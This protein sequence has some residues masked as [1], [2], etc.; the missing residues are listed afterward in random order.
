MIGRAEML[1][2]AAQL[3]L[4]PDIVEKDY[5]LG[6]MLA[7]IGQHPEASQTW[8]FKGGTCLKKVHFETYR[9]SEDLDFTL[10]DGHQ[11]EQGVLLR[12]LREIATRVYDLSGVR[13]PPDQIR[14]EVFLN[15]RGRQSAEARLY[16]LGPIARTGST[17]AIRF[18]LTADEI[19]VLPPERRRIVHPYSDDPEDGITVL[20]YPFAEVFAE[21]IRALGERCRPRDLYDVV[22]LFR[23]PEAHPQVRAVRKIL[24][25]K[26]NHKSIAV[27]GL[28]TVTPHR[29]E[30]E[31]E[32]KNMLAAQLP[33]LPDVDAYWSVLPKIFEWLRTEIAPAMPPPKSLA[34][35]ESV[36]R[37]GLRELPRLGGRTS[38]LEAIRFAGANHLCVDLEYV[39][40]QGERSTRTIE[41]YSLRRTREGH[42]L[43]HAERADGRGHRAYRVDRILG[44]TVTNQ[45][46]APRFAVE[47]T[48]EGSQPIR[49]AASVSAA[50]PSAKWHAHAST[51][52]TYV[53]ECNLCGRRF[54]RRT[55]DTN[56]KPHK[57]KNDWQCPGRTGWLVDT[58]Y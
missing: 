29:A 6:W 22:H 41:P 38:A 19:M 7:A 40:D 54:H 51:G 5:V 23:R 16:Y 25:A 31:A 35:G 3:S 39:T 30:V 14:V 50:Y 42:V 1:E 56:L 44:A 21:K 49:D 26:C 55:R 34:A 24:E 47:L 46:F 53:Y 15:P 13:I 10:L 37:L 52:P 8:V 45:S 32:W 27:P 18:D 36:I 11:V 2:F 48:P 33:Q 58:R 4:R 9:F 28:A 57:D 43:L 20:C 17:P 12:I